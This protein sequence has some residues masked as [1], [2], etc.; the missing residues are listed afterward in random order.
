MSGGENICDVIVVGLGP[1]GSRAAEAAS[2]GGAHVIAVDRRREA[3]LPVQ[4]AEF[5]PAML[6]QELASQATVTR[7][8]I[9]AM[10]TF[11]EDELPDW[12][13][14][15]PGRMIDR[16][17]FDAAL[18]RRAEAAGADCRFGVTVRRIEVDGAVLLGD[19][20]WIRPH[21]V[22]GADGPRSLVGRAIG[23][24]NAALVE[25][26]QVTVPLLRPH[27]ATDIFLSA[28]IPGGYGWLFPKGEVANL[29]VGVDPAARLRLKPILDSLHRR[30]VAEG[31]VGERVLGH[32]GGAIAVGGM[33]DP[34]GALGDVPVLLTGDAAG[35]S[36]PVTGAGIASAVMSGGLAGVAAQAF[37]AGDAAAPDDYADDVEDLFG[38]ALARALARRNELLA[39][40]RDGARPTSA[41]LRRGW[42]AYP[43]Y[44]A[45]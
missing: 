17:Q 11:V 7:Q 21:A 1:A 10:A 5:V 30:L 3:G 40:Y 43:E 41:A 28:E 45:A 37:C 9:R 4:C 35:L 42:I 34:V 31:R 6:D 38:T 26:R 39:R 24:R 2:G 12:K 33:L 22:I 20:S 8:R 16:A 23:R 18:V 27:E 13:D 15:F 19:G 36:N 25:T 14:N 32:T 44:W 29:G